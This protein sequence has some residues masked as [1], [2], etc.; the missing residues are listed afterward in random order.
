MGVVSSG[1]N[2]LLTSPEHPQEGRDEGD[3]QGWALPVVGQV[4][5]AEFALATTGLPGS[6]V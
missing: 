1:Q 4:E 2:W 3:R 5:Y 6:V